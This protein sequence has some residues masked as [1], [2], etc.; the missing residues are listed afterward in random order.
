MKP[1]HICSRSKPLRR[2]RKTWSAFDCTL[3]SSVDAFFVANENAVSA[4]SATR[5]T[6]GAASLAA[7]S[8][9]AATDAA[10][11]GNR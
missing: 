10:Q 8:R 5:V 7:M 4:G 2:V 11:V 1:R 3:S 6:E 9:M